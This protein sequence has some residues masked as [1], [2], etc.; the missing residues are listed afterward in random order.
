MFIAL[1]MYGARF[2][3]KN[4][5]IAIRSRVLSSSAVSF[6]KGFLPEEKSEDIA[7]MPSEREEVAELSTFSGTPPA[8]FAL[9]YRF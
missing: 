8:F 6:S 7:F 9:F 3:D 5:L 4:G 1:S 2:S